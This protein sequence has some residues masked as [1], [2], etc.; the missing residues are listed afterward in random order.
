[1]TK[2]LTV[3]C[4]YCGKLVGLGALDRHYDKHKQRG[5]RPGRTV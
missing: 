2:H 5:P 1:M 4:I 3:T